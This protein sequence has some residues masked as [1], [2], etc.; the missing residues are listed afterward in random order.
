MSSE[1][2]RTPKVSH[3]L[4][5]HCYSKD[6]FHGIELKSEPKTKN[7]ES[8]S[9][10]LNLGYNGAYVAVPGFS[11]VIPYMT[12]D[13]KNIELIPLSQIALSEGNVNENT[14][15]VRV[16]SISSP[17]REQIVWAHM[18]NACRPGVPDRNTQLWAKE[19]LTK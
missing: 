1:N 2:G 12:V 16:A 9:G 7:V 19:I 11:N 18:Q 13:L 14:E 8:V 5:A 17:F 15:Y 6:V 3:A 4:C 10:K